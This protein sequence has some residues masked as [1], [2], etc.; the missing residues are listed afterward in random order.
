M[1]TKT[2][3][4]VKPFGGGWQVLRGDVSLG[5]YASARIANGVARRECDG[6]GQ[7]EGAA[8]AYPPQVLHKGR[9]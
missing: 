8:D 4:S 3:I 6:C 7:P 5:I 2:A 1:S 9:K